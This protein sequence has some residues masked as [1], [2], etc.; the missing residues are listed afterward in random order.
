MQGN[1]LKTSTPID[2][3]PQD[4]PA[5]PKVFSSAVHARASRNYILVRPEINASIG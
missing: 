2:R 4:R 3:F 1:D 5:V